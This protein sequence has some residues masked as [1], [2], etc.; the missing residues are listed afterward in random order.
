MIT[1]P[2]LLPTAVI[3]ALP[4][5][6]EFLVDYPELHHHYGHEFPWKRNPFLRAIT[7]DE[8][9]PTPRKGTRT[10]KIGDLIQEVE[11]ESEKEAR[12]Q[13]LLQYQHMNAKLLDA[14]VWWPGIEADKKHKERIRAAEKVILADERAFGKRL[15]L[16]YFSTSHKRHQHK[17]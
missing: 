8:R 1:F 11:I 5:V 10:V 13:E 12:Q 3:L 16:S 17:N 14:A 15:H 2:T 6:A 7:L 9:A 4:Y